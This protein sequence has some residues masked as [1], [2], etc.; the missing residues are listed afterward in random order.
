MGRLAV[1]RGTWERAGNRTPFIVIGPHQTFALADIQTH[2]AIQ[3][4]WITPTGNPPRLH[5]RPQN[6]PYFLTSEL[7]F[8]I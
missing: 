3:H 4:I 6:H 5:R 8:V 1:R 2:G 7:H